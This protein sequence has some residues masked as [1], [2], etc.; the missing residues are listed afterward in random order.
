MKFS[1]EGRKFCSVQNSAAGDVGPETSFLYHQQGDVVW[2]EYEGGGI[3][4]GHLI[5]V[6]APDGSLDAR[7]H[8]VNADGQLM[9]G[10]CVSV[11]E[12]LEDGRI[13]LLEKWRWTSGDLSSGE[14]VVE[15]VIEDQGPT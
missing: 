8:H 9:T 1:Y 4:L 6:A 11:P 10:V 2:A 13:R 5:A 15:E 14:S 7:Y 3:R 12:I